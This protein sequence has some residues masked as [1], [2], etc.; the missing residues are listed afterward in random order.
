MKKTYQNP[1]MKLMKLSATRIFM[2]SSFTK[3]KGAGG[4]PSYGGGGSGQGDAPEMTFDD[5]E[6]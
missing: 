4:T 5:W 3:T 2:Q 1:K 6:E